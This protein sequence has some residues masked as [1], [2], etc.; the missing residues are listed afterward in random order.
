VESPYQVSIKQ[1]SY[2]KR[3]NHPICRYTYSRRT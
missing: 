3:A 2:I 1:E